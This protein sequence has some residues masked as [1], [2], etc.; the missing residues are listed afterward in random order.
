MA[1]TEVAKAAQLAE[2]GTSGLRGWSGIIDE[3]FLPALR[4]RRG[5][6]A[7]RDMSDS[8]PTIGAALT[9]I[10]LT[11]R[12]ASWTFE[13]NPMAAKSAGE[14]EADFA[15]SL[16]D[17]M[18][19]T[20]EDFVAE[21]L[22]MMVYGWAYHEIVLKRRVGPLESAPERRSKYT[23]GRIGVRKLAPRPQ[24]T[25][26][27]WDL[28][29]DGG[30][31]GMFQADF[32]NLKNSSVEVLI[33]I[34]RALLFRTTS[35]KNNPEGHS[36]LRNAY[37]PH[38][39]YRRIQEMEGIGIERELAGVPVV[40]VPANVLTDATHAAAKAE[41]VK[42]GRDLKL[43]EHGSV[44]IPSDPWKGEDGSFSAIP[45]YTVELIRASGGRAIDTMA[46]KTG[47]QRDMARAFLADFLM[48]GTDKGAY[49]LSES[50]TS[51]FMKT[52]EALL[53]QI[54][55]PLN[56]FL[57]PRIWDY[58][59]LDRGLLPTAKPGRLAPQSMNEVGKFLVDL[60]NAG[61]VPF[62]DPVL[63]DYIRDEVG[64]PRKSE[65]GMALQDQ[66]A[67]A[68]ADAAAAAASL[69]NAQSTNSGGDP[70]NPQDAPPTDQGEQKVP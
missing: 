23:D 59:G 4:G 63:S 54:A 28:Q 26:A 18:S 51:L 6:R 21:A 8:D 48:L 38:F 35:R 14:A 40:R 5:M 22:S 58:N 25:L 36:V 3:E 9:A 27:R 41:F 31:S 50:K 45:K 10:T 70:A 12:A 2:L 11:L 16:F 19:H 67:Q 24:D 20:W 46:V 53:A 56:R 43:N 44:V 34:E 7:L 61:E 68:A 55:A 47:Y 30:V 64:F 57:L 32:A 37:R 29:D 49:N 65:E 52:C 33:P 69:A 15:A 42:L 66:E 60:S 62:P 13:A 39:F 17:D 1:D